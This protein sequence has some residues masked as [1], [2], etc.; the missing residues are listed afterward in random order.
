MDALKYEI[1]QYIIPIFWWFPQQIYG[2]ILYT[3]TFHKNTNKGTIALQNISI[4]SQ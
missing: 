4:I 3:N 1:I 2:I